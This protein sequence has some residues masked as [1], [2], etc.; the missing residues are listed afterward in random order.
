MLVLLQVPPGVPLLMYV[1]VA[2]LQSGLV[3]LIVPA[4]TLG[5][6]VRVL[7]ADTGEKQPLFTV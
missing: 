5:E 1:A 3:P 2:P 6:T 7:N 4:F